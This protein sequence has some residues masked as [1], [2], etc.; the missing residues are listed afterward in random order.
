MKRTPRQTIEF[1]YYD[2]PV[3]Q[4][5]LPKIGKGWEQQYGV[6]ESGKLHFHNY[7]EIGFCYHGRGKLVISDQAFRYGDQMFTIIPANI[8][9]TTESDPGNI[10]KWEYL[11]IDSDSFIRNEMKDCK[12][13]SDEIIRIVNK[14]G[15]F[16]TVE[17][18]THTAEIIHFLIEECRT[19]AP[20]Y[21]ESLKGYLRSL[22]IDILRMDQAQEKVNNNV[23]YNDFV[24]KATGYVKEHYA[25]DIKVRD[26]AEYCGLS[27]SHFRRIFEEI[28]NMKPM[29]YV[30][31][32]RIDKACMLLIKENISM[33]D[34]GKIVGY[35]TA[36][37]FNRNFR[38]LTGMS[39]LQWRNKETKNGKNSL[40]HYHISALKGWEAQE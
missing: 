8:P 31:M 22:I 37:S 10:C 20:F 13:P 7:L 24:E 11:F 21:E 12:I 23:R 17:K 30:N 14:Q 15:I 16:R 36:S 6:A 38:H 28:T 25:E 34:L 26:I 18:N 2:M 5:V 40:K 39:P 32:V 4:Y 9:H 33:Q 29:D 19:E 1:R 35:Q 27:E 3:E